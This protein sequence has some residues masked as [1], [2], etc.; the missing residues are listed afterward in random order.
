[1]RGEVGN[2]IS[3]RKISIIYSTGDSQ[4]QPVVSHDASVRCVIFLVGGGGLG[5]R[6]MRLPIGGIAKV[7]KMSLFKNKNYLILD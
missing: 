5:S 2:S 6:F 3:T 7:R 1:M 4:C